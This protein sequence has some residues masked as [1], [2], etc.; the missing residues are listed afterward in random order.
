MR[1]PA[2]PSKRALERLVKQVQCCFQSHRK[3]QRDR[4]DSPGTVR[5]M[6]IAGV[7]RGCVLDRRAE[8]Q[9]EMGRAERPSWLGGIARC[10]ICHYGI[11]YTGIGRA[12]VVRNLE[13]CTRREHSTF[14]IRS[15]VAG[16][17][18]HGAC[19]LPHVR[20]AFV[21]LLHHVARNSSHMN[22]I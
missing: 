22:S 7:L 19:C 3:Y 21:F 11:H 20:L 2:E 12:S 13:R 8:A 1:V 15:R 14:P 5:I 4:L 16:S 9:V 6:S 18:S 10:P 17:A